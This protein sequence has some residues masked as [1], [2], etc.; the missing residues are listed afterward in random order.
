MAFEIVP[1]TEAGFTDKPVSTDKVGNAWSEISKTRKA[2]Q[3]RIASEHAMLDGDGADQGR[4]F[5]G[6][7]RAFVGDTAEL[8]PEAPVVTASDAYK[9]GRLQ[10][11]PT[12]KSVSVHDGTIWQPV[13]YVAL[14]DV[15]ESIDG[16]KTFIQTPLSTVVTAP[17]GDTELVNK[18]QVADLITAG[19]NTLQDILHPVGYEHIRYPGSASPTT[20]GWYGTWAQI[21]TYASRVFRVIA[22]VAAPKGPASLGTTQ[23]QNVGQ[24]THTASG[25]SDKLGAESPSTPGADPRADDG[26]GAGFFLT[27]QAIAVTVADNNSTADNR[28]DNVG[29][30][31]WKRTA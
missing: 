31:V 16:I 10:Y 27:T 22:S 25:T 20:M 8:V 12:A 1:F 3:E 15:D 29:V 5:V 28:M 2:F 26:S 11:H 6:S 7:A 4:H 24:H 21:D 23:A 14:A 17:A 13:G 9:L 18:K 19:F 30:E